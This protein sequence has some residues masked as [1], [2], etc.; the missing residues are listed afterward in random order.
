[1]IPAGTVGSLS[2]FV[3]VESLDTSTMFDSELALEVESTLST[4]STVQLKDREWAKVTNPFD[5]DKLRR[6]GVKRVVAREK[7]R[8]QAGSMN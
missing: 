8:G 3:W 2:S 6:Q 1:M 4:L 5:V 7:G